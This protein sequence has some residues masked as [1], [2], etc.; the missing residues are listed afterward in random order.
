[1]II[2]DDDLVI[3]SLLSATLARDF[4]VFGT[5][6]DADAAIELAKSSQPDVALVDVEMPKGGGRH[7]LRGIIEVAP[8]TAVVVLSGD[9][10]EGLVRELIKDGAVAYCRKGLDQDAL[11]ALLLDA[12]AVRAKERAR[13]LSAPVPMR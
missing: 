13:A 6:D 7:A 2:A 4:E 12:V 8:Q 3:R 9:E 1:L 5:A 11:A 10:S